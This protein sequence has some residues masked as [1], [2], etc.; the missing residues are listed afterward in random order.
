M[1]ADIVILEVQFIKLSSAASS[2]FFSIAIAF[3]AL[4]SHLPVLSVWL[5]TQPMRFEITGKYHHHWG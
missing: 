4:L 5:R 3:T 1:E 2:Q